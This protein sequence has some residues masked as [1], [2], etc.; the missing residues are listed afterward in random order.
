M[1]ARRERGNE[2]QEGKTP[3]TY[4]GELERKSRSFSPSASASGDFQIRGSQ[5][6]G[7]RPHQKWV[8]KPFLQRKNMGS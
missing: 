8:E 7:G 4:L 1:S 3:P 6:V 2:A 5:P